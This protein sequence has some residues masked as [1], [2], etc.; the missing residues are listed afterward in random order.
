MDA[1]NIET[2]QLRHHAGYPPLTGTDLLPFKPHYLRGRDRVSA[3]PMPSLCC[4]ILASRAI[5][6]LS[7][8]NFLLLIHYPRNP[9]L[10]K[11]ARSSGS[12][13]LT[14]RIRIP[15]AALF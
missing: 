14:P 7:P 13:V 8:C 11:L 3:L 2:V 6:L 1:N 12:V 9:R 4:A 10:P 5:I 15:I